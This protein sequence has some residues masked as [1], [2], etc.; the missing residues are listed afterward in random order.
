L[1]GESAKDIADGEKQGNVI[2]AE[3]DRKLNVISGLQDSRL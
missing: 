1:A 2:T 3:A